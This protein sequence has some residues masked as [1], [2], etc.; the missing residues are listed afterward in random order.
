MKNCKQTFK[1]NN[2]CSLTYLQTFTIDVN[3]PEDVKCNESLNEDF[4]C[5]FKFTVSSEC[6]EKNVKLTINVTEV[7][8]EDLKH[9]RYDFG[10]GVFIDSKTKTVSY[11]PRTGLQLRVLNSKINTYLCIKSKTLDYIDCNQQDELV[12]LYTFNKTEYCDDGLTPFSIIVI[13]LYRNSLGENIEMI[14]D[15]KIIGDCSK[16]F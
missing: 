12:F 10:D 16:P 13:D 15:V 11:F 4:N 9:F 1:D 6:V 2:P 14:K 3:C 8:T 7:N 5:S